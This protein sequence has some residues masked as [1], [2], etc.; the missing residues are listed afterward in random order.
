[1]YEALLYTIISYVIEK[2]YKE[3][4]IELSP[5]KIEIFLMIISKQKYVKCVVEID[6]D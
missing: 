4:W 1:M 3:L 6:L 5:M 2:V